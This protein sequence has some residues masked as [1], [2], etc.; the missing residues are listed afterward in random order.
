VHD[1]KISNTLVNMNWNS[2]TS[3]IVIWVAGSKWILDWKY[4][5]ELEEK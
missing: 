2:I 3:D 1:C 4:T 5:I